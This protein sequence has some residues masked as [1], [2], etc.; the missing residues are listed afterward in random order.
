MIFSL[1]KKTAFPYHFFLFIQSKGANFARECL[2]KF[3]RPFKIYRELM[4]HVSHFACMFSH[5]EGKMLK[6]NDLARQNNSYKKKNLRIE[7][8]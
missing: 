8:K 6:F 7:G 3:K 5:E 2:L 1:G 4:L